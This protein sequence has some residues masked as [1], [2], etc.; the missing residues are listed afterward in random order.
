VYFCGCGRRTSSLEEATQHSDSKSHTMEVRG[1]IRPDA[2]KQKRPAAPVQYL[3]AQK[4][5]PVE[6]GGTTIG[7]TS[8]FNDF[9]QKIAESRAAD[10]GD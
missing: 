3:G 2:P 1:E 10:E 7:E 9:R 6:L 5:T 4:R 8:S